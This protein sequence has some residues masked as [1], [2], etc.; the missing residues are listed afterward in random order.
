MRRTL[1]EERLACC[2]RAGL[3][4]GAVATNPVAM[5]NA[6]QAPYGHASSPTGSLLHLVGPEMAE[7]IVWTR[8]G[9]HVVPVLNPEA[10]PGATGAGDAM[11][12]F[13]QE[14]A[15]SVGSLR[16]QFDELPE[17]VWII[18]PAEEV[19]R[20]QE[21]LHR[22][23]G[24]AAEPFD[25]RQVVRVGSA[26]LEHP[27]RWMGALG[28]A[29]Q[30]IGAARLPLNLLA[31]RQREE[32]T[33]QRHRATLMASVLC[34]AAIVSFGLLGLVRAYQQRAL[35]L[36]ALERREGLYQELRPEIRELLRRQEHI[37]ARSVL[38]ERLLED[39]SVVARL[40]GHVAQALP[41]P[42]WLTK[43][44]YS[45]DGATFGLL[46]GYARSFQ[47]VTRFM[48]RLKEVEGVM[49]VKPLSTSV[50]ADP[51]SG[52]ERIVFA[53]QIQHRTRAP[54]VGEGPAA[55]AARATASEGDAEEP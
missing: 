48:D 8:S 20:L 5:V 42:V 53:I 13:R 1:L 22:D 24:L 2:R 36:Q 31:W 35:L 47:E 28:L 55:E 4:V 14:L 11:E 10:V 7:W 27:E 12:T 49:E 40:L 6:W 21:A 51:D 19:P 17:R 39:A 25:V 52:K 23:G 32:R 54:E 16:A 37:E 44:D 50:L 43:V 33:R 26:Q 15:A 34:V 41:D 45:R 9:L 29:L 38:L 18:G 46:E 30:G 3:R